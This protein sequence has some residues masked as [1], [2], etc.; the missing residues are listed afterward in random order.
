VFL[1]ASSLSLDAK[2]RLSVPARH[3]EALMM[4]CKGQVTI[5][6]HYEGCLFVFPQ[7]AWEAFS[8]KIAALSMSSLRLKRMYL[9]NAM[10]VELDGTGRILISPELREAAGI[11]KDTTLRGMGNYFELW[12]KAAYEA[13]DARQKKS[14]Q[15]SPPAELNDIAL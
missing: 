4:I 6:Q 7:P 1:G 12:D 13:Y 15:E 5:T 2:G 11:S 14:M 9:S 8:A 3:H 10:T